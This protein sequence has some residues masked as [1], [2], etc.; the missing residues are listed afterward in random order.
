MRWLISVLLSGFAL[1]AVAEND[2]AP[3][4]AVAVR[5]RESA[6]RFLAALPER[7][8]ATAM[9]TF[10][11]RDR[12]D[13]H[14][15][16]RSRNGI[17]L[18]ELDATARA[19][20]HTLL[21]TALSATGYRKVVNIIELELVLRELETFGLMRDPER[22]HVTFYGNPSRTE[23]WG[24]RFE[25]HTCRSISRSR[26]SVSSSTR[27]ASSARIR[28]R[29]QGTEERLSRARRRAR[30]RLDAA[31]VAVGRATA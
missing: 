29:F 19:A 18:K 27:R 15:T 10:D 1:S 8:R 4:A 20:V 22:Y 5:M 25:G 11:D 7:Q 13:W 28:R 17:S 2:A 31:R 12:V 21:R 30:R 6:E 3:S 24:W 23:R 9:R 26:A 14:Y 16:P